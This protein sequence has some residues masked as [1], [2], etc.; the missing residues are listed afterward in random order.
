[1]TDIRYLLTLLGSSSGWAP[2]RCAGMENLVP[3][4][5]QPTLKCKVYLCLVVSCLRMCFSLVFVNIT[6]CPIVFFL[7]L[8][9]CMISH[10]KQMEENDF[11][12]WGL[13]LPQV[14][15]E[16]SILFLFTILQFLK[17]LGPKCRTCNS[18]SPLAVINHCRRQKGASKIL[19]ILI[20]RI[21]YPHISYPHIYL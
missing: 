15:R 21:S 7:Q 19:I 5:H 13:F 20:K 2:Q 14:G 4:Y 11:M 6:V 1:M 17:A 9:I 12:V 8:T 10:C 18:S 3:Y 16:Y